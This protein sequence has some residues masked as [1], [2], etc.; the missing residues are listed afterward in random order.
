ML[1]FR[2]LYEKDPDL[3]VRYADRCLKEAY[4]YEVFNDLQ[5]TYIDEKCKEFQRKVPDRMENQLFHIIALAWY[6]IVVYACL[7]GIAIDKAYEHFKY[8]KQKPVS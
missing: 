2:D 3:E 5:N 1:H 6:P 8:A 4:T 7:E